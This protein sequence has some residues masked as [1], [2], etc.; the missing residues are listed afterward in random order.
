MPETLLGLAPELAR[1]M[2]AE[3]LPSNAESIS[4]GATIAR[5]ELVASERGVLPHLSVDLSGDAGAPGASAATLPDLAVTRVLGEGGMGRVHL[6]HQRSLR[7]DVA[8]KTL[9]ESASAEADRALRR[10]AVVTG[11][12]EHPGIIPVHAFGEA[13][14]GRPAM[15]MKRVEGV[16]WAELMDDPAHPH[17]AGHEGAHDRLALQLNYLVR[18]CHAVA[19]A[20][21]RGIVHRDLKPE[22]VMI[23]RFGE[24][25][26]VDWGLGLRLSEQAEYTD[27]ERAPIVGTPCYMAPEMVVGAPA[28]PATDVYLLGGILHEMLTGAPTHPGETITEV[29]VHAYES[30]PPSFDAQVPGELAEICRDAL[31][32]EPDARIPSVQALRDRIETFLLHRASISLAERANESLVRIEDEV[33]AL[34]EDEAAPTDAR[35]GRARSV[36]DDARFTLRQALEEWPENDAALAGVERWARLAC[37]IAL[38]AENLPAARAAFD[39]LVSDAPSLGQRVDALATRLAQR[40]AARLEA[41]K[42]TGA[43]AR[44]IATLCLAA[45]GLVISYFAV[46][47]YDAGEFAP[48]DAVKIAWGVCAASALGLAAGWRWVRASPYNRKAAGLLLVGSLGLLLHRFGA[49]ATAASVEEMLHE[50][51][52]LLGLIFASAGVSFERWMLPI[53][54]AFGVGSY[55]CLVYPT[56]SPAIFSLTTMGAM[57]FSAGVFLRAGR[58]AG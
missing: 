48:E 27:G 20:H 13:P 46:R 36:L 19:F 3:R 35:L 34:D 44:T 21:T 57:L 30:P 4:L 32:R 54:A 22:N 37:R 7:R 26:V 51:C 9:K 53:A 14:D 29:M 47:R 6:A 52:L 41:D 10:E 56:A 23:G 33:D 55:A 5:P 2:I 25:Y 15:V 39:E 16:S 38:R 1:T 40:D 8:V 17:W 12:L 45:F 24:V 28:T 31:A 43:K 49:V 42:A 50:D 11:S 58:G 18:V